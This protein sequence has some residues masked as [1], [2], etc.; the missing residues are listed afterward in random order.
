[1]GYQ[2]P[3]LILQAKSNQDYAWGY[4][5]LESDKLGRRVWR[6]MNN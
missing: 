2:K 4:L 6:E 1:M 5:D 3:D